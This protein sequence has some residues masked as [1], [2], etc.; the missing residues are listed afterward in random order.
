[1]I[2]N[3][4]TLPRRAKKICASNLPLLWPLILCL[5][6]AQSPFAGADLLADTNATNVAPQNTITTNRAAPAAANDIP[7]TDTNDF[8]SLLAKAR[9]LETTRQ[10]EKAE[11]VLVNL[12]A[13][14]I[15]E[16]VQKLALMEL[17]ATVREEN[18]LP[19]AQTIYT[20]FLQRWP[21]DAKVPEILLRQGEIFRQMG[22]TDL[23]L[24]KFYSV[25]TSALS[26]K[27]DQLGYYQ[28]LVLQTQVEI[29]DTHYLMGQYA[30]AADFYRRLLGNPA[31]DKAAESQVQFRL[32]RSLAIIGRNDEAVGQAQ[33]F[34]ARQA[35]AS[36]APEVRYYLAESLK[37][38]GRN[39]EALQQ[40]LICLRQQQASSRND[41][42][43][44]SYWRQRVGNEIANQLYA[45]GDFVNALEAYINLEQL[46]TTAAWQ[47]PVEYQEAMTYENLHQPQKAVETYQHILTR[48]AETGTN[49]SPGLKAVFDMARWRKGFIQWQTNADSMNHYLSASAINTTNSTS[50]KNE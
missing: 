7:A 3:G 29:A 5:L 31:L 42:Q 34:L 47:V 38:L 27:N 19:R 33:D 26:L 16:P 21:D 20:Q 39:N 8:S 18:D 6:F 45:G 14:N 40:V 24:G 44:W 2:H 30:D 28:S 41:P 4:H 43:V 49:A 9:Q 12:L 50:Q 22:L 48:E 15:P 10:P 32:I 13:G 1:M 37:A 17:G 23:A 36:Q 35:E 46:D 25:M 11:P